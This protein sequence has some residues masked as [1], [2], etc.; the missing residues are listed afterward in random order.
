[1]LTPEQGDQVVVEPT[2]MGDIRYFFRD[3]DIDHM[4]QKG[5]DLG[6]YEGVKRNALAVYAHT[7]PEGDMPPEK[8][9]KWSSNR[10]QTFLNWILR[11]YPVGT[12]KEQAG[13][14][15]VAPRTPSR[16]RKNVRNLTAGEAA[17]LKRAFQGLMDRDPLDSNS[18]YAIAGLHGLPGSWCSHHI[19][20]YNPWHRIF[21]RTFEDALRSVPGCEGVTLPYWDIETPLPPL[22]SEDPFATYTLPI[23]PGLQSQ[24]PQPGKYY[25]Y[26]IER[27]DP[28]T[29]EANVKAF[30]MLDDIETSRSQTM[31]GAYNQGGYQKFS[32]QAHDSGHLSI[33]PTMAA[34]E[35]AAFDPVF[36]FFHCNLDRLWLEWQQ[37]VDATTLQGFKSTVTG[38][39]TWLDG[40]APLDS[41]PPFMSTNA[42]SIELDVG[43]EGDA[44]VSDTPVAFEN[45][46]GS[47]SADRKFKIRKDAV[48]IRVKNIARLNIP[49]SFIVNLLA[50]GKVVARRAFFQPDAPKKCATCAKQELVNLDF[51]IEQKKVVGREISISIEVPSQ[52]EIGA[53][54]PLGGA[55]SP[56]IN[57]RLLLQDQ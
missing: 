2:Y 11:S 19:N 34:Q 47:L 38:D 25:P 22:L 52:A 26:T 50:D 32:I 39:M 48:S 8:E 36:W 57:A 27:N 20:Q 5:F 31:W 23:D 45:T 56:T 40:P 15:L 13:L 51:R 41:L 17:L 55:G 16:L 46:F 24:A 9:A 49:G 29:I 18:Y 3:R 44:S 1:M 54:F 35:V 21:L 4:G 14:Q 33:G 37:S 42:Q 7:G 12:P 6:S 43:Y 53:A 10:K 30:G 28:A